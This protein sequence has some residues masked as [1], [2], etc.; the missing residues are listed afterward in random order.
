MKNF[1]F[2]SLRNAILYKRM[3]IFFRII[4]AKSIDVRNGLIIY[5]ADKRI[6]NIFPVYNI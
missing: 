5:S 3:W 6:C 2:Y 1:M 4:N